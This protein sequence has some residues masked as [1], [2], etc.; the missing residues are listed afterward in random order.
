MS[1]VVAAM[2]GV[3]RPERKAGDGRFTDRGAMFGQIE[4]RFIFLQKKMSGVTTDFE[5]A[6][7]FGLGEAFDN[8]T[9]ATARYTRPVLGTAIRA[10]AR[11]QVVG[12]LDLGVGQEGVAVFMDINYSF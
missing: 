12:S 9:A 5:V 11:P 7:F 6:P 2:Q 4:Q 10:I 8:P 3:L 1:G